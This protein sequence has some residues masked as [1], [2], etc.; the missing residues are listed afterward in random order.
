MS[1]STVWSQYMNVTN[2]TLGW[3]KQEDCQ[4]LNA[5][6]STADGSVHLRNWLITFFAGEPQGEEIQFIEKPVYDLIKSDTA[7]YC[8]WK[9]IL[10]NNRGNAMEGMIHSITIRMISYALDKYAKQQNKGS[11]GT[12]KG[13]K[14]GARATFINDNMAIFTAWTKQLLMNQVEH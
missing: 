14:N 11:D 2:E 10:D 5:L 12:D 9:K 6:L 13:K 1:K 4:T 7:F 3:E 8:V